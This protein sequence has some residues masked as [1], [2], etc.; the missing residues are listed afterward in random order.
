MMRRWL[1]AVALLGAIAPGSSPALAQRGGPPLRP[2]PPPR[3]VALRLQVQQQFMKQVR[4]QLVLTRA[5]APRVERI[6]NSFMEERLRL[7]AEA[8]ALDAAR[9]NA[10][11]PGVSTSADSLSRLVTAIDANRVATWKT[12]QDEIT[13]LTPILTPWQLGRYQML[14]DR[15]LEG[16]R[17]AQTQRPAGAAPPGGQTKVPPDSGGS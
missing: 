5:Q 3:V 2:P 14:R 12:Y 8:R 15:L 1:R 13:A 7:D 16:I 9:R 17:R 6:V 10:L 11:R 4:N